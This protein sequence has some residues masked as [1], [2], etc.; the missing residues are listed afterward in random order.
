MLLT[1]YHCI[2]LE[3][4]TVNTLEWLSNTFGPVGD[5]WFYFNN[6]LYFKNERDYF[7]F[8]LNT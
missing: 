2:E 4:V 3:N 7:W 5:R 1:E 8:E 6:K